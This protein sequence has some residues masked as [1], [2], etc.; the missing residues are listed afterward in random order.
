MVCPKC[1]F[2][3]ADAVE[4]ARCGVI[5]A[6]H[7]ARSGAP[8]GP[9]VAQ[10]PLDAA[11]AGRSGRRTHARRLAPVVV[12]VALFAWAYRTTFTAAPPAAPPATLAAPLPSEVPRPVPVLAGAATLPEPEPAAAL[13]EVR[14][15]PATPP[16]PETFPTATCPLDTGGAGPSRSRV[17]SS[18]YTHASFTQARDDQA[19]VSAPMVIYVYTD[20]CPYCREFERDL[21]NTYAVQT[22]LRDNVV[23]VRVNPEA[24]AGAQALANEL[25]VRG[26]PSFFVTMPGGRP[27]KMGLRWNGR[28]RSPSDFIADIEGRMKQQAAAFVAE[29]H[30]L[31]QQGNVVEAMATL[32]AA[33]RMR[34]DDAAPYR[35]THEML[36]RHERWD[37][38]VACWTSFLER[39]PA[40]AQGYLARAGAL[41]RR[42][43]PGLSRADIRKACELGETRAC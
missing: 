9:A 13:A 4:C 7:R 14:T 22:Y 26:F 33:I 37:E 38:V 28:L 3:Q 11:D 25:G 31:Q 2:E 42:G 12:V 29:G 19:A 36:G 32:A 10:P 27:D 16:A 40:H 20:W 5:V 39:N 15:E 34:P 23:K 21:L 24:S 6:R 1:R 35:I 18:W 8:P 41:A 30:R 17:S 43:T